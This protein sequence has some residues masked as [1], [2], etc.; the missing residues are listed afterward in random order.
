MS[1]LDEN[2]TGSTVA[3]TGTA[4]EVAD[5]LHHRLGMGLSRS[6]WT[7]GQVQ[8]IDD[9]AADPRWGPWQAG[10]ATTGIRSVLS[11]PLPCLDRRLGSLTVYA[12]TPD[13]FGDAEERLLGLL[14]DAAATVLR[15][16]QDP[17]T[18]VHRGTP[19]KDAPD[20][21]G[22]IGL[23]AGVLM[24]R[25]RLSPETARATLLEAAGTQG[26]G[27]AEIAAAVVDA[28]TGHEQ[29]GG[30]RATTTAAFINRQDPSASVGTSKSSRSTPTCTM[31]CCCL[32]SNGTCWPMRPMRSWIR[33][34]H[35]EPPLPPRHW[36][37]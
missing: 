10:A 37:V 24:D 4:V 22:L 33:P 32:S 1:L 14:A 9:T 2:G 8:R 30:L 28:A 6:A 7:T 15:T 12:T 20:P 18:P 23:A 36:P 16:A 3:S 26:R 13:A 5:T 25:G 11:V 35:R 31:P 34:H 27:L 29:A 21:D 17:D 19:G